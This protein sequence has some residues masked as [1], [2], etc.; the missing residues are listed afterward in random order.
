MQSIAN[1]YSDGGHMLMLLSRAIKHKDY[2]YRKAY[3][4]FIAYLPK[5]LGNGQALEKALEK[6]CCC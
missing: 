5:C 1:R 3:L 6:A 2:F 4:A